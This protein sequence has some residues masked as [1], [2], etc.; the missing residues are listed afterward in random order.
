MPIYE[1]QC[2]ACGAVTEC[3]VG[4]TSTQVAVR[5]SACGAGKL[6]RIFSPSAIRG[7]NALSDK[8]CAEGCAQ[9]QGGKRPPCFNGGCCG[10]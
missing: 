10:F 3:L 8:P 5:C 1:Y 2:S 4:V 7:R 6:K 9:Q